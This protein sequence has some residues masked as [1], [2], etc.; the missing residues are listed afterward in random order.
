MKK[1][2]LILLFL[3][4]SVK[5]FSQKYRFETTG[6]SMSVID[7]NG[8]WTDFTKFKDAKIV[9]S[10][11]TKKNRITI[12]SEML[13]FYKIIN[14]KDPIVKSDTEIAS[15]ECTNQEGETCLLSIYTYKNQAIK[16]RLYIN[17][18]DRIFAYNMNFVEN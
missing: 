2:F 4:V 16:N 13:Q 3:T 10:L 11:D 6:V 15:F 5:S 1:I 17:Y 14:Y 8:K 12:Y 18:R 7:K 9:I